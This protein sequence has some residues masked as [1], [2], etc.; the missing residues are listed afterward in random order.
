MVKVAEANEQ[1]RDTDGFRIES[2]EGSIGRVEEVWVGEANEPLALAVETSDGRHALLL[3]EEVVAVQREQRWIVVP[4]EPALL[5]LARPH[6]TNGTRAASATPRASWAT[7]GR[8]LAAPTRPPRRS[9]LRVPHLS[10]TEEPRGKGE[11]PLWKTIAVLY[12]SIA[13]AIVLLI[14]LSFT[15]AWLVTGSAY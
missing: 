7:T 12:A 9:H 8:P 6:M 1:L 3:A 4:A 10:W 11:P 14:T 2:P 5:E 15:L 13:F